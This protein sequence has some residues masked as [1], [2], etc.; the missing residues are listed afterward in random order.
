MK[1][2]QTRLEPMAGKEAVWGTLRLVYAPEGLDAED[3][4]SQGAAQ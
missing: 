2:F 3:A 1:T 4:E